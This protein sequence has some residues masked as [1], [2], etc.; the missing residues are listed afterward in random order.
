MGQISSILQQTNLIM[1][2]TSSIEQW[3]LRH[4]KA[5]FSM[6]TVSKSY[7][8]NLDSEGLC[9]DIFQL[10]LSELSILDII[11][12]KSTCKYCFA[13]IESVYLISQQDITSWS[14]WSDETEYCLR[15]EFYGLCMEIFDCNPISR[16]NYIS[17]RNGDKLLSDC[18]SLFKVGKDS[19]PPVNPKCLI[20]AIFWGDVSDPEI[21]LQ[22]Q[23]YIDQ[24][25][26][27]FCL[28]E[29]GPPFMMEHELRNPKLKILAIEPKQSSYP[30]AENLPLI[31]A[32]PSIETCIVYIPKRDHQFIDLLPLSLRIHLFLNISACRELKD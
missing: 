18:C 23:N 28:I 12:L 8:P 19:L 24:C 31:I 11:R 15:R 27:L 16:D 9:N 5:L 3:K 22:W 4:G 7:K 1:G 14:D 26:N 21:I 32:P 6:E 29:Q 25:E 30:I 17:Y 20:M 10:I 2:Q 13:R